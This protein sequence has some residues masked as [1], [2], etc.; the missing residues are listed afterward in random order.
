MADSKKRMCTK[1]ISKTCDECGHVNYSYCE[2]PATV[3]VKDYD[4]YENR[5]YPMCETHAQAENGKRTS[6]A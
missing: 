1:A 2:E 3:M 5:S 6:N 4:G